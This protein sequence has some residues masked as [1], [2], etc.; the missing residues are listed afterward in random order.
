MKTIIGVI[1]T[2][3]GYIGLATATF[4]WAIKF[5]YD[6]F[7]SHLDF[8][9]SAGSNLGMWLVQIVVSFIVIVIG[10]YNTGKL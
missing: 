7:A 10:L 2:F 5:L 3:A 4:I 1:A 8:W 6:I 9:A